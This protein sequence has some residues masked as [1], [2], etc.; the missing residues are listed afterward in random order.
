[1]FEFPFLEFYFKITPRTSQAIYKLHHS[2]KSVDKVSS[3]SWVVIDVPLFSYAKLWIIIYI[4][5]YI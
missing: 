3:I 5:I 4:N 2:V 1:M